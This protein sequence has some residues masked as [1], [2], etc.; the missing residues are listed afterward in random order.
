M[1]EAIAFHIEG[2]VAEG[3]VAPAASSEAEVVEVN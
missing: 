3:L 1:Q 2:M